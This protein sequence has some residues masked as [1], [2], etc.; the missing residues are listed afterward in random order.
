MDKINHYKPNDENYLECRG[1]DVVAAKRW[2]KAARRVERPCVILTKE[3]GQ[4]SVRWHI[5]GL[6]D[7]Q[8]ANIKRNEEEILDLFEDMFEEYSR[9]RQSVGRI[10]L[11]GWMKGIEAKYARKLAAEISDILEEYAWGANEDLRPV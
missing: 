6:A 5:E 3:I 2:D 4:I 10:G 11:S 7:W 9:L 8:K 1:S